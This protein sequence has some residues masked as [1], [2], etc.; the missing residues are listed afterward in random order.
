MEV[1]ILSFIKV[2]PQII[3]VPKA[4]QTFSLN[5]LLEAS[6]RKQLEKVWSDPAALS[7]V[8]WWSVPPLVRWVLESLK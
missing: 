7:L 1:C 4:L 6:K 2:H 5:D 3:G 8:G